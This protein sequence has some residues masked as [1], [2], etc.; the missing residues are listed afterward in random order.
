MAHDDSS[1][2]DPEEELK[3]AQAEVARLAAENETLRDV[4]GALLD[5]VT[6]AQFSRA[7]EALDARDAEKGRQA[8]HDEP[9]T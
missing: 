4:V 8:G 9:S 2:R 5:E 6:P 3:M 1:G 7:R